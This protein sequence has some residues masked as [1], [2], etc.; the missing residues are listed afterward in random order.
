M[1]EPIQTDRTPGCVEHLARNHYFDRNLEIE[2]VKV[3]PGEYFVTTSDVLIVTVLG[4]C[5]A[6]CI[7][8]RDLGIG[9]M[10]HFMSVDG[11]D[12]GQNEYSALYGGY[13]METLIDNLLRVGAA[14]ERL[15]AKVFGGGA[16][17]ANP[18]GATAGERNASFVEGYLH[19]KGI[20]VLAHDL[21]G[22]HPRKVYYF[23]NSGR[24]L[25][26]KILRLHND[27]LANREQEYARKAM[28][29]PALGALDSQP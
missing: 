2:A 1:S 19:A 20:P 5:V 24:V 18:A 15:E 22:V 28:D 4:S 10:N 17:S 7:R 3:L 12:I 6:A 16:V 13:A 14:R 8:D 29:C 9:G 27:T 11:G 26:R 23:P 25:V 21:L